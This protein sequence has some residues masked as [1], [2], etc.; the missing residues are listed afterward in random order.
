MSKAKLEKQ[1]TDTNMDFGAAWDELNKSHGGSAFADGDDKNL[2]KWEVIPYPSVALGD[3][4]HHWGL[5]I[6]TVTQLHGIENSGKTFFAM[7]MVRETLELYPDSF[8][9][10]VNAEFSFD[11]EWAVSLG[12]DLSRVK[13]I[14]ENDGVEIFHRLCGRYTTT[15][16]KIPGILDFAV[17]GK[18]NVKL[19]VLDSIAALIP[20]AEAGRNMDELE[21]GALPKFLKR[22]FTRVRPLLKRG[23]CSFIAINQARDQMGFGAHG[24][25]YPGGKTWRHSIDFAIRLHPSTAS[26][27]KIEDKHGKVGH[28][29]IATVEK[30]RG[31]TNL[32]QAEFWLDFRSGVVK[33]GEELGILA[34]AYGVVERPNN[35]MWNYEDKTFKGKD[36][37]YQYLDENKEVYS[38]ILEK[39]KVAKS[40]R[41]RAFALSDEG[42]KVAET[43]ENYFA[44]D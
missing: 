23:K 1:Q 43:A 32:Y 2:S 40:T 44:E 6:G 19:V 10:W 29:I 12:I 7:L 30:C 31:G 42:Q 25:T 22:A 38:E 35:V 24:I 21:M 34:A 9:V 20:P 16:K 13:V 3:A 4:T 27:G 5:P 28:K 8:V 33:R 39:L 18:L 14:E 26:D 11:R 37:F 36:L 17:E 41:R 15:G